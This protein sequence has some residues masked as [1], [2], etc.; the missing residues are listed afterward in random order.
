MS[1]KRG[2]YLGGSTILRLKGDGRRVERDR[3]PTPMTPAEQAETERLRAQILARHRPGLIT[4][5]Q[6][7]AS[8]TS[9]SRNRLAAPKRPV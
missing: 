2:D 3:T 1:K 6:M 4:R 7:Q 9:R 5:E 8:K